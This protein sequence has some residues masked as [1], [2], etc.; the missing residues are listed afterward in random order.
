MIHLSAVGAGRLLSKHPKAKRVVAKAK[1]R[2]RWTTCTQR[3]LAQL[4]GFLT[5]PR[6]DVHP[7]RRW[8]LDFAWPTHDRRRDPRRD[9]LRRSRH[10]RG[11]FS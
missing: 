5:R 9:P 7:K 4:V 1:R 3:V 6:T 8:R 2:S 11:G 10:T